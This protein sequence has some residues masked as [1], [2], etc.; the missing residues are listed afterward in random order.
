MRRN[1]SWRN[2]CGSSYWKEVSVEQKIEK[3][4]EGRQDG[5]WRQTPANHQA[6]TKNFIWARLVIK[7]SDP[8]GIIINCIFFLGAKEQYLMA[9][10]APD[11]SERSKWQMGRCDGRSESRFDEV[12]QL[13]CGCEFRPRQTWKE[14]RKKTEIRKWIS[15]SFQRLCSQI[16]QQV[17]WLRIAIKR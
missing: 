4:S 8:S 12:T 17:R 2:K 16:E 14:G 5:W 13:R 15:L 3:P 11:E 6:E 9:F 1:R 10:D 7:V